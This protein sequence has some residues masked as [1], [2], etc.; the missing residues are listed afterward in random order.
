M[1]FTP[2]KIEFHLV[3]S[4]FYYFWEESRTRTTGRDIFNSAQ[5][6]CSQIPFPTTN[7]ANF[8]DHIAKYKFSKCVL[9]FKINI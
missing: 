1:P 2:N 4:P 9:I 7:N 5:E 3:T 6:S 8:Q